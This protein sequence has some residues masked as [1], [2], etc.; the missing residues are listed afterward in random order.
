MAKRPCRAG[1]AS[2]LSMSELTATCAC[3]MAT[4]D[5]SRSFSASERFHSAFS[6]AALISCGRKA[7]AGASASP[8]AVA[9]HLVD[10]GLV[11]DE[12]G[13]VESREASQE[14][15]RGAATHRSPKRSVDRDSRP[16]SELGEQVT[17][18]VVRALPPM[19]CDRRRT[20]SPGTQRSRG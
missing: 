2:R 13:A 11:A 12:L 8:S 20:Q 19:L 16:F 15:G 7:L 1:H 9:W 10:N 3:S 4:I 17:I 5:L 18:S 6:S 14:R